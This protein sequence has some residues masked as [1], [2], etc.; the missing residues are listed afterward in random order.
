MRMM[1]MVV[2]KWKQDTDD[3]RK[4]GCGNEAD[5]DGGDDNGGVAEDGGVDI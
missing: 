5:D 3:N 1:L 4:V 2:R